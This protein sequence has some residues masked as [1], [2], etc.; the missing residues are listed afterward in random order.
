MIRQ[1]LRHVKKL[2]LVLSGK[3]GVGKSVVS[4]TIAALLADEGFNTGLLDADIYGPSSALLLGAHSPPDEGKRGLIP[5]AMHG[6]KTMSIDLFAPS[7]PVSLTGSGARQVILETLALTD[8]G[9]LDYLVVDMPPATSD[10]MMTLTS[11]GSRKLSAL[12]LTMPDRLSAAVAHRVL[13]LLRTG[14]VPIVGVLGNMYRKTTHG[15]EA[16]HDAPRRLA[17]EFDVP[18]W[19][20][21]PYDAGVTTAVEVGSVESLLGTRFAMMLRRLVKLHLNPPKA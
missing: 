7:L 16:G 4:A 20:R 19:G 6:I 1:R 8:W 17:K 13:V 5:P 9:D 10:I 11:L 12:V 21:L 2:L 3:G 15:R 14:R 18:F